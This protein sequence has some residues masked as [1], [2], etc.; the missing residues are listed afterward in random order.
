MQFK[1]H[2]NHMLEETEQQD[3]KSLDPWI[4]AQREANYQSG[5]SPWTSVKQE[6]NFFLWICNWFNIINWF[7]KIYIIFQH[8]NKLT[9]GGKKELNFYYLNHWDFDFYLLQELEFI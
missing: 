6:I 1:Y 5:N 4:T 8:D 9:S 7:F 2:G 3:G